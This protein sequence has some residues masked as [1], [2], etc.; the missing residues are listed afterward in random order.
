MT[1]PQAHHYK[2]T[3]SQYKGG[4]Q[5]MYVTYDE[6]QATRSG[7]H[8]AYAKV[9]RVYISG[10]VTSW[11]VGTFLNRAGRRVHGV[12]IEYQQSRRGYARQAHPAQR[13]GTA[14][15]VAGAKVGA[16]RAHFAKVVEVPEG[17][18]NVHFYRGKLPSKYQEALQRV[19]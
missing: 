10:Q 3:E 13:G 15:K 1:T 17:A 12:K 7:A 19:R 6:S 2:S 16:G 5:D 9:K 4:A 14:Y 8:A 11:H 18:H